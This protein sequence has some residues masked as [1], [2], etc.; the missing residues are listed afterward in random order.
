MEKD[1]KLKE[2]TDAARLRQILDDITVGDDQYILNDNGE[3]RAAILSLDH[4]DLL[5]RAQANK[6]K[7]WANL[8]ATLARVH[9]MNPNAS[10]QEIDADVDEAIHEIRRGET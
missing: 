7:S 6:E 9:A 4:L 10:P 8:F 1:I 2:L 5:K 3:P